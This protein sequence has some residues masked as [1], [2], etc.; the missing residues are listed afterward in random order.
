MTPTTSI[1][2]ATLTG[3]YPAR[4]YNTD[5]WITYWDDSTPSGCLTLQEAMELAKSLNQVIHL[6]V[7]EW[8]EARI[9]P[10]GTTQIHDA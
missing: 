2:P 8:M 10:N 7:S 6:R 1:D 3:K 4:A 9:E 5:D